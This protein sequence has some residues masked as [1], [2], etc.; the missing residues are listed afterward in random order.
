MES[1]DTRETL[2][3][4]APGAAD[5]KSASHPATFASGR[6]QI[7]R[8]IG[9]GGQKRVYLAQDTY[10]AREV[11]I[12]VLKTGHLDQNGV[13]RLRRE[14]QMMG[15][16]GNHP[17]I[18]TVHDIGEEGGRPYIVSQFIEGGSVAD[19]LRDSESHRLPIKQTI[20]IGEQLCQALAYAHSRGVVHRDLKPEN[21]WLTQ[22][23]QV[24]LGDFGL[25]IGLDLSRVS[26]KGMVV[27]TVLY[28]SPEQV[29]GHQISAQSDLYSLGVMLYE[30][31]TGRPLFLGDTLVAIISQHVNTP[32]VAPSWHNAETPEALER[33]ILQMLAKEPDERP[34]SAA[35]VELSL[36][37]IAS[38]SV[39]MAQRPVQQD[40]KSL[41]R[42]A[43]GIFV[44]R[45]LEMADLQAGLSG[46]T[47]GRGRLLMLAGEPGSGKTRT[48]EQLATYARLCNAE[49]LVGRCYEGEG[50]PAFWPWVQIIRAYMRDREP[51][52]L[53][54]AM[55]RCAAAIGQVVPDLQ[56][57][58][59]DL[60][61]PAPLEPAQARFRQ[62]DSITTFLKDASKATPLV[63][64]LDDLHWADKP[65]LLLLEF[66][67]KEFRESRLLIVGTFRDIELGRHHPLAQTLAE[68]ARNGIGERIVL[69]GLTDRDVAR[70][71]EMTV[72]I[73][74][75][76]KLVAAVYKETEGNPFFVN[77][78]VRLLAA[79]GGLE[80]L[81]DMGSLSIRIPEGVREVIGRRLDHLSEGA[82][83]VLSIASV[84]GR[85]FNLEALEPL[86]DLSPNLFDYVEEALTAR[87]IVEVP[88][89]A[90][91][92]KFSHALIRETLYDEMSTHRRVRLHR[93]VGDVLEK[94]HSKMP[95]PHLAELAHHFYQ[96]ASG[97]DVDKAVHYAVRAAERATSL[98]AYEEAVGHYERALE[99][100]EDASDERRCELL[101][102]LGDAHT[103]AGS[104]E[105]SRDSFL[106]A[107]NLARKMGAPEQLAQA[108]LGIGA[109]A[110]TGTTFGKVDQ[111]QV[112]LLEESLAAL[113]EG[114]SALRSRLLAQLALA[115]Y[116]RRGESRL[117]LSQQAVE[118]A[119]RVGDASA[120]L[121][122]LYSR[123]ITL[124][125]YN[126][127]EERLAAATEMVRI[128]EES[129]NKERALRGHHRRFRELVEL[130][131]VSAANDARE[132]YARLAEE[133]RQPLY[134]WLVPFSEAAHA[135][136]EG[137]FEECERLA[138]ESLAIGQRAQ[139]D[140]ALLFF[141]T[142]MAML[143]RNQGRA[144][145]LEAD[146][147]GFVEKYTSIR[148]WRVSL[149]N[150]YRE[151][152]RP[153]EAREQFEYLASNDF[154]DLQRDGSW[155]VGIA[156]LGNVCAYLHDSRRAPILYELLRPF[157]GRNVVVGSSAAYHGPVSHYLGLLAAT[158]SRWEEATDH[159]EDSLNAIAKMG[160]RP[161]DA[162]TRYDYAAM[163]VAQGHRDDRG[164]A[165]DLLNQ[166]LATA[167]EL[168]MRQ[169]T[170]EARALRLTMKT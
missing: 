136:L 5:L 81:D 155:V 118:M 52:A 6:Y 96:A 63:L 4:P 30:M 140:N 138:Q 167:E 158:M 133:L 108:T 150:I 25:A 137:R 144:E 120:L 21:V 26:L 109:G 43:G 56:E 48:T 13:I 36:K 123:C 64:I 65:S 10:L 134:L 128:A 19:L 164:K 74:P 149:A 163:L 98:L 34:Q 147:K 166:A 135:L 100:M 67:A 23:G 62:F 142:I 11:V 78:V 8:L 126:E 66:L 54:S 9:E 160:A 29:L 124:E 69:R 73:Q 77:E 97:G 14:A 101:L 40:A 99:L 82:N 85:E 168:G 141:R 107:A 58:L 18:V 61:Q 91:Q 15:R 28:M 32:P 7:K 51:E 105:K 42:L 60:P 129:G 53:M 59:P 143:R 111:V 12:S 165:E 83:R 87:I 159:F 50:S 3:L 113:E 2:T 27:G 86:S 88:R 22:D 114:D 115:L 145:E 112:D 121:D 38:S 46:A 130:G 31:V 68:L 89:V 169:L 39:E 84:L 47:S 45:Q 57:V 117:L 17:H 154:A 161:A 92:Y 125:G 70:F 170:K 33:L 139:G 71:I 106:S 79:E 80:R 93:Q 131:D 151:M 20:Q 35:A 110:T 1:E 41:A 75:P 156:L 90:G 102:A 157:A 49:V 146:V 37:V 116:Y 162:Y 24:M 95:D 152:E 122:A 55:G 103:K 119:R 94:L 76:E 44:G 148:T 132:M 104:S 153:V 127:A 16:L 72:G